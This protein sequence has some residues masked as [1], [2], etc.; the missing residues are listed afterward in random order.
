M[1][2]RFA[3]WRELRDLHARVIGIVNV[4]PTLTVAP[5]PRT[6][7]LRRSILT[8]LFCGRLNVPHA[9]RKMILRAKRLMVSGGRNIQ[10]VLNPVIAIRNL[11]LVPIDAVILHAALPVKLEAKQID[12]KSIFR[13][14]VLYDEADMQ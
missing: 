7:N 6:G 13:S 10:H 12:V 4:E 9:E 5:N 14:D 11:Q 2:A 3:R 1:A 8:K